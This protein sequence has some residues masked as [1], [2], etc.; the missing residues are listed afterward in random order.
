METAGMVLGFIAVVGGLAIAPLAIV[1]GQ[2][3]ERRKRELEHIERLRA[4]E[5]GRVLPQDEPW[6]SPARIAWLIGAVVPLGAFLSVGLASRSVGY[7][8][9]MWGA[10]AMVGM[11][12]VISGSILAGQ[13]LSRRTTTEQVGDPKPPVDEDAYDV[14]S[15]RG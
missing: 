4:L 8:E 1:L 11:A 15:A 10:A 12:G 3:H 2:R 7:H 14:V 13:S 6:W 5:L 9:G